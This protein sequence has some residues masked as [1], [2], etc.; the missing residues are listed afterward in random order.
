M[1]VPTVWI[2]ILRIYPMPFLLSKNSLCMWISSCPFVQNDVFLKVSYVSRMWDFVDMYLTHIG[3][4]FWSPLIHIYSKNGYL[5]PKTLLYLLS[6]RNNKNFLSNF[7]WLK[8][9]KKALILH[10]FPCF[11]EGLIW[12]SFGLNEGSCV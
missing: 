8:I 5:A 9:P 3:T 2:F 12:G 7:E 1:H 4:R 11:Q 10:N 6:T